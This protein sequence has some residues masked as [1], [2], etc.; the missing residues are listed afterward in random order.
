MEPQPGKFD[1]SNV[2]E[3]LAGA[4]QR[5]LRLVLLWFGTW[6]NWQA[7]YI[8]EWMKNDTKRYP[9]ALSA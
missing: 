6:K 1:F 5:H 9:R 3:L 2:D 4:R 7:H 8:P